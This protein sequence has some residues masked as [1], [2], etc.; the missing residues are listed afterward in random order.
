MI[1]HSRY[2]NRSIGQIFSVFFF[3]VDKSTSF[4]NPSQ[5]I[6]FLLFQSNH[7][8]AKKTFGTILAWK[9]MTWSQ[10][11]IECWNEEEY[12]QFFLGCY[13]IFIPPQNIISLGKIF[14]KVHV[15][16]QQRNQMKLDSLTFGKKIQPINKPFISVSTVLFL[17]KMCI[18]TLDSRERSRCHLQVFLLN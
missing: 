7:W 13:A 12:F 18:E 8:I 10:I 15:I 1:C 16:R 4:T 2:V 5:T 11:E 17:I 14:R 6:D 3:F 9:W